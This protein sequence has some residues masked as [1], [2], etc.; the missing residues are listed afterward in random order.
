[1]TAARAALPPWRFV[2][3]FGVV[4]LLADFVYE[5]ARSVTGPLLGS[6][7]GSAA[8]IG[9]VTGAGDAAVPVLYAGVMLADALSALAT[10][11]AYD[12]IGVR[13]L[14]ALPLLTAAVPALAFTGTVAVAVGGALAWG[15]ALGVQES[16]L[17]ATVA[18]LVPAARRATAYGVFAGVV[19]AATLVG[20]ALTGTL[21]GYSVR[22]LVG[23]VAATQAAALVLLAVARRSG[24]M[25][26]C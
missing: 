23:T 9:V 12:R 20:G 6:L 3:S 13:A 1:M 24:R 16:T 14:V 11:W 10:G 19:G 4:S 21:Y 22:A 17:L 25:A 5:G 15:A 2:V 8:V 26:G 18:D 7:G